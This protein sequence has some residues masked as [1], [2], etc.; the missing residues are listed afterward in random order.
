MEGFPQ[1]LYT[2][3]QWRWA[4]N[5][6]SVNGGESTGLTASFCKLPERTLLLFFL[7]ILFE[8]IPPCRNSSLLLFQSFLQ[9]TLHTPAY[10]PSQAMFTPKNSQGLFE[11]CIPFSPTFPS[12]KKPCYI[13][14]AVECPF[15]VFGFVWELHLGISLEPAHSWGGD[16]SG[17]QVTSPQLHPWSC[18]VSHGNSYSSEG[19]RCTFLCTF[20]QQVMSSFLEGTYEID[21]WLHKFG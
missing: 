19:L 14:C 6:N 17:W 13:L 3:G 5:Q 10:P 7:S 15:I 21:S 9:V 12:T 18:S 11:H 4:Q 20:S 16:F 1:A 2:K 8:L